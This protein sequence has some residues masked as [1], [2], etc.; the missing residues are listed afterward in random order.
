MKDDVR[1]LRVDRKLFLRPKI[2]PDREHMCLKYE[3]Q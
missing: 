3:D 1:L 2:L